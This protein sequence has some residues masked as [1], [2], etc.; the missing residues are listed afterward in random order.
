MPRDAK[1]AAKRQMRLDTALLE[2]FATLS[3]KC[4]DEEAED[5]VFFILDLYQF[6]GFNVPLA[7]LDIDEVRSLSG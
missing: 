6:H 2:C 3:S 1:N 7:E 5:L 4:K